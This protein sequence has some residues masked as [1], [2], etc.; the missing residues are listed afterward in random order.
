MCV[1]AILRSKHRLDFYPF[2]I[3][4]LGATATRIINEVKGGRR[5]HDKTF[6]LPPPISG[7]LHLRSKGSPTPYGPATC[8][9]GIGAAVV[10]GCGGVDK[11]RVF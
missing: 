5:S 11:E 10:R 7:K 4:F 2:D 3:S 1:T 6:R 8:D 9:A